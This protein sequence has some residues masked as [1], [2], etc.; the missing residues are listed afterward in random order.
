MSMF[1]DSKEQKVEIIAC[2][3][4][5]IESGYRAH[6]NSRGDIVIPGWGFNIHIHTHLE[7]GMFRGCY[8]DTSGG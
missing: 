4:K 7:G 2:I 8:N 3:N 6:I 5:A 1:V